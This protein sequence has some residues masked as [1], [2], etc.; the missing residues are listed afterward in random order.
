MYPFIRMAK[1]MILARRQPKLEPLG[2]H[3][4]HHICWPWDLDM[5]MELNNGRTLTI[6]DL[7][8]IPLAE[9]TGVVD[10]L[11]R[12]RWGLTVA[13]SALR[14]RKRVRMFDRLTMYSRMIG[15]DERFVYLEQSMWNS[16]GDCTSHGL[17][18]TAVT[19]KNG[20]VS[21]DRVMQAMGMDTQRPDL[22]EWVLAWLDAEAQ[23]PWPPEKEPE[24][25]KN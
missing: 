21:P 10:T 6:F 12:E 3:V 13:G 25:P 18:R 4:S 11:K 19:D 16:R 14:Y 8:R 17:Y 5:W 15:W 24:I 20:I 2:T 7:G 1:E 22:P 9:R 23:R